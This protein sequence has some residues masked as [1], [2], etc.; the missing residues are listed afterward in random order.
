MKKPIAAHS[1]DDFN[2]KALTRLLAIAILITAVL[3]TYLS[4]TERYLFLLAMAAAPLIV[5]VVTQPRLALYQYVFVLFIVYDLVP[6]VPLT[7]MDVSAVLIIMAAL[8]DVLF[9]DR[10]PKHLPRL[11]FNYLYIIAALIVCGFLGYW[12][13][14]AVRRVATVTLLLGTF[15]AVYRLAA[16]VTI[17]ELVN[18]FFVLAVAHSIY[19]LVPF[20]AEGG[21]YR[22]FGFTTVLFDDI[23]MVALPIGLSLYL[24]ATSRKAGYYLIGSVIVWGGLIA[25][26]S[27]API[28]L[29]SAASLFV[30]IVAYYQNRRIY[31][32][33]ETARIFRFRIRSVIG[34]VL[35]LSGLVVVLKSSI[36]AGVVDRFEQLLSFEPGSTTTLRLSLWKRA[37][38]AFL[39]HPIFGVGPGGYYKLHEIYSSW[40]LTPSFYYLRTLGA[41]NLLLHYLADTGLVGG[42]G[43]IA[44][45]VNQFKIARHNWLMLGDR[46]S[47]PILA[48]YGWAFLFALSTVTE[49]SWM[50]GQL[51]FLA[52]FFAALVSRQYTI[53]TQS[54][55]QSRFLQ[56]IQ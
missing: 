44:L 31:P 42:I 4:L 33:D 53:A 24:R 5:L 56:R 10:L 12:P 7:I 45:V 9:S 41:H 21:S 50:W 2:K 8:L 38:V 29:A 30:F 36:L 32:N 11:S 35:A 3:I 47:E 49:A 17:F 6:S 37:L 48:L 13:Q 23:A 26:Q 20:L 25:T 43:L 22:S 51:S 15:L 40:H 27:R 39:D 18:C 19:V 34:T 16:K 14:L 28:I 54:Q 1:L 46:L 55:G 52:I